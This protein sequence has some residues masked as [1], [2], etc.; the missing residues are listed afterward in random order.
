MKYPTSNHSDSQ[1]KT[2]HMSLDPKSFRSLSSGI[3][4]GQIQTKSLN[5]IDRPDHT[6]NNNAN[7]DYGSPIKKNDQSLSSKYYSDSLYALSDNLLVDSESADIQKTKQDK[8]DN[9]NLQES[10]RSAHKIPS[11]DL[12]LNLSHENDIKNTKK[13]LFGLFKFKNKSLPDKDHYT[14]SRSS[15]PL[16]T[17]STLNNNRDNK[18]YSDIADFKIENYHQS[19]FTN[20]DKYYRADKKDGFFLEKIFK[21]MV[22]KIGLSRLS[23]SLFSNS[24]T[25]SN[26]FLGIFRNQHISTHPSPSFYYGSDSLWYNIFRW[27][28]FHLC[29]FILCIMIL[30][31]VL[32][33]LLILEGNFTT[34][35]IIS[36]VKN[37]GWWNILLFSYSLVIITY[38]ICW[39]FGIKSISRL[40]Y[41][42]AISKNGG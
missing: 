16:L 32:S 40:I 24:K 8:Y 34:T 37:I 36:A 6:A 3:G 21:L 27:C 4:L 9:L 42:S 2:S 39:I 7:N 12:D 15:N 17:S 38:G 25:V 41:D 10:I 14:L 1:E 22:S 31:I 13:S 33:M 35:Q 18:E 28:V 20:Y 11:S 5:K 19:P 30:I 26:Q 23:E 29:D